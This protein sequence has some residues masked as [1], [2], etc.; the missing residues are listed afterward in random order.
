MQ[1]TLFTR[2]TYLAHPVLTSPSLSLSLIAVKLQSIWSQ[3]KYHYHNLV[4]RQILH[5]ERFNTK[6]E[7]FEPMSFMYNITVSKIVG[8]QSS[9]AGSAE[10]ATPAGEAATT[11]PTSLPV[12]V[13]VPLPSATHGRG[14]PSSTFSW[15]PSATSA[16]AAAAPLPHFSAPPPPPPTTSYTAFTGL[17]PPA[18][19]TVEARTTPQRKLGRPSSLHNSMRGRIIDAIKARPTL[20]A[21]R[22]RSEKGPGGPGQGQSRTSAVWKEAAHEMGLTP[23]KLTWTPQDNI[24]VVHLAST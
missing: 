21:G 3:M 11:T 16:S 7:H 23:S 9:S 18:A 17:V 15:L 22:Q 14:R 19:V 24:H 12:T 13:T 20:W 1:K 6:W 10:A 8:A 2:C 4:H 5:K